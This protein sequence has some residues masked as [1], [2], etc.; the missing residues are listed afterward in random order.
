M[1][2]A[3]LVVV[4]PEPEW[5]DAGSEADLPAYPTEPAD[6]LGAAK[7]DAED[8]TPPAPPA[9]P[10]AEPEAKASAKKGRWK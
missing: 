5:V 3:P 10:A 7:V 6:D 4:A 8:F 1:V 2:V 9:E